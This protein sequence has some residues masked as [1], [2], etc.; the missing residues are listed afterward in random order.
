MKPK[1]RLSSKET[2]QPAKTIFLR[3]LPPDALSW[4]DRRLPVEAWGYWQAFNSRLQNQFPPPREFL[5]RLRLAT[6]G[7]ETRFNDVERI[8]LARALSLTA[9][10]KYAAAAPLLRQIIEK[11]AFTEALRRLA[12]AGITA[13]RKTLEGKRKG[14]R[15]PKN[16]IAKRYLD[17][18]AAAARLA[19]KSAGQPVTKDS[20]SSQMQEMLDI[21]RVAFDRGRVLKWP[22]KAID[23]KSRPCPRQTLS[24]FLRRIAIQ[25]PRAKSPAG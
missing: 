24:D 1:K 7:L 5:E 6:I 17:D 9:Q 10:E 22:W 4:D 11:G 13:K 15:S 16:R 3:P 14:G 8:P 20:L 25:T 21:Q 18:I 2:Q 23:G 12:L 19:L